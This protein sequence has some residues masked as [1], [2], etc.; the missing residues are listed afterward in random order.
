MLSIESLIR[1]IIVALYLP[2]CLIVFWRLFPRL[3]P[4]GMRLASVMLVAQVLVIVLSQE[5]VP[6]AE[7]ERWFWDL[8]QERNIAAT[9]ASTQLALVGAVA[10]LATWLGRSQ[11][12]WQRL[13]LA[14]FGLVFLYLAQDE[15]FR[16]HEEIRNWQLYFIAL[17]AVVVSATVV[18]AARSS[19]SNR[20]WYLCL[21]TGIAMS[22]TGAI[23]VE[24][25]RFPE[26]CDDWGF[27]RNGRCL[28]YNIEEP[29]EFLGIWLTLVAALGLFSIAVP[30]PRPLIRRFL[31]VVPALWILMLR[32]PSPA[33]YFDLRFFHQTA[34][35]KFESGEEL[36]AYRIDAEGRSIALQFFVS[37]DKRHDYSQAQYVVHLVDQITGETIAAADDQSSSRQEWF[38]SFYEGTRNTHIWTHKHRIEVHVPAETPTNRAFWVALSLGRKK[39][40]VYM[41]QK[42]ISSDLPL[43]NETLVVLDERIAPAATAVSSSRP[44]ADSGYGFSLVSAGMPEHAETGEIISI[45]SVRGSGASVQFESDLRLHGFLL[46][47][48]KGASI[49]RLYASAQHAVYKMLGYSIHLLDQVSG[50]TVATSEKRTDPKRRFVEAG[51]MPVYH[52]KMEIVFPPQ[53]PTNRALWVVLSLWRE[54]DGA[55]ERQKIITSDHALLSDTQVVLGEFVL[56]AEPAAPSSV[57]VAEFEKGFT[58]D[59]VNLP[60]RVRAGETVPVTFSWSTDKDA[61]ED[62]VQF[63][64]FGHEESGVW[65]GYDQQP[66]GPRLPTRLW[67]SGLADSEIWEVALPTDLAPGRYKIYTGL[68]RAGDQVRLSAS[69]AEGTSYVDARVPLGVLIVD[70]VHATDIDH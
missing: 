35:V 39:G 21:L 16:V 28:L 1:I 42:V 25:F 19:Q 38:I 44:V 17:G 54:H 69:D 56:H 32:P 15:F 66:L 60:E 57:S 9:L 8:D 4:T 31:Y 36:Q 20:S 63:L 22:A 34:N 37:F 52:R 27:L 45:K 23:F 50:A 61:S 43:L 51:Y 48:S 40:D 18:V 33:P 41:R 65:W 30:R 24:H 64:H 55:F 29:L 53:M 67:Y 59:A 68:Y 14:G 46:D 11:P 49:I 10:F 70:G 5:N 7:F 6:I 58:L 62:I 2:A 47:F 3:S 12:T 26:V 13:Y